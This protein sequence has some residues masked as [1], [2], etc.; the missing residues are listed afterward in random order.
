MITLAAL[1]VIVLLA[2]LTVFQIALIAGAPIARFAW[3]GQHDVLPARLRVGSATSIVLYVLFAIVVLD[4][5]GFVS[6]LP[7]AVA[8]IGTW[9]LVAYFT[10][11][12][13]LNGISRSRPE[14]FTMTPICAL[15]AVGC[16]LVAIG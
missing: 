1:V 6:V 7:S 8:E 10:L 16:L 14:R 11:G 12:I 4:R 2:G 5:A 3:G 13:V 9:V 15:L